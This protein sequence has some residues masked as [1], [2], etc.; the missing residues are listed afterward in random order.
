[1]ERGVSVRT[2]TPDDVLLAWWAS[3]L[4]GARQPTHED[5][6]HVGYYRKRLVARG[7]WV[8]ASIYVEREVCPETGELLSDE[9]L[10]CEINGHP[11]DPYEAWTWLARFPISRQEFEDLT[12]MAREMTHV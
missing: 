5:E 2:P 11:A 12:L 3:A 10:R 1:V 7:P 8:P 4:A 6:P 9:T